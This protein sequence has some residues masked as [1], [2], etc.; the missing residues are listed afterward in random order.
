MHQLCSNDTLRKSMEAERETS[1][2]LLQKPFEK[3]SRINLS[4]G[5]KQD[6]SVYEELEKLNVDIKNLKDIELIANASATYLEL[7]KIAKKLNTI[8]VLC[9][10]QS[11]TE[12]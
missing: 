7:M 4:Q 1:C 5:L 3:E 12:F 9:L 2:K 11:Y 10:K 6:T 8:D